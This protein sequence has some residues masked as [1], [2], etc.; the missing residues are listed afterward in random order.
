M[1]LTPCT[2]PSAADWLTGSDLPWTRLVTFGPDGFE[3]YARLRFLPDP[4][5]PGQPESSAVAG[6]ASE[7]AVLLSALSVLRQH[8]GTPEDC[9]FCLWDGW[10]EWP[11]SMPDGPNVV[12]P[13]RAYFLFR[14]GLSEFA[15]ATMPAPFG[16]GSVPVP[17]F[18]WPADHAWC[19]ADDVDPH[20]AGIGA[21]ASTISALAAHP[22]LDVVPADPDAE[23]PYFL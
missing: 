6:G 7:H 3:A 13:A 9:Y 22:G 10:G 15:D 18:I 19:L 11:P 5:S 23:Q 4:G 8:T 12:L 2:D 21:D 1:S 16:A 20:F 17:A 14:G